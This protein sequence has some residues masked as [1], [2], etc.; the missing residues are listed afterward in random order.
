MQKG[1]TVRNSLAFALAVIAALVL[2]PADAAAQ[3]ASPSPPLVKWGKWALLGGSV[4]MN[5]MAAD[6]HDQ[7]NDA[8]ELIEER[9]ETDETLCYGDEDGNYFDAETEALY[10]ETLRHD[11]RARSWLIGGQGALVGAAALFIWE[12]TRPQSLPENI[13]FDPEVEVGARE[14]RIGLNV[15]F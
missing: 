6:A 8:F 10:Q 15:R 11:R 7:A 9:C 14:T 12:F 4:A 1:S 5:L 13:P 3:Q 2:W